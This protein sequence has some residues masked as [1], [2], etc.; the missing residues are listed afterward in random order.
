MDDL[1]RTRLTSQNLEEFVSSI[2]CIR[3]QS[4]FINDGEIPERVVAIGDIHGDL[5][6][7]FSILLKSGIIDIGGKWIAANTFLVQTGDLFDKGRLKPALQSVGVAPARPGV[8][9]YN[10]IDKNGIVQTITSGKNN[11]EF[12]EVGDELII[13]KFLCDLH[14]QATH[15]DKPFGNS[16]VLLC[17]GNHEFMNTAY[18]DYFSN[19]PK[20]EVARLVREGTSSEIQ[21]EITKRRVKGPD[22]FPLILSSHSEIE[23]RQ[24]LNNFVGINNTIDHQYAHPMD[25][26]LFGGPDFL[27]RQEIFRHGSG[28]LA[29][30]LA[31]ILNAV[32]VV[33]DFL[34]SHGGIS[35]VNLQTINDVRE[36]QH[37]N[38]IFRD[39]LMGSPTDPDEIE[40]YFSS[41]S[42]I[43]WNRSLGKEYPTTQA[44]GDDAQVCDNTLQLVETKLKRPNLNI[45][46]G[47][48][49]QGTCMDPI[50]DADRS[51]PRVRFVWNRTN[52]HDGSISTCI[53]LPTVWCKDRIYRIDT[54]ISRMNNAPDFRSPP[55]G[56]LN[57]LII[58]L[59][60]DGSK[61]KVLAMNGILGLRR[62]IQR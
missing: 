20:E 60:P 40:R 5:E 18:Y 28:Y 31:C 49:V 1:R 13:L 56:R 48:D 16:R 33:G 44:D 58:D 19:T 38:D 43:L 35:P 7:L 9:P 27:I 21:A 24:I 15:P 46:V 57:S 22:G 37:I 23:N 62:P 55:E 30:K 50:A 12:G 41:Q 53:T 59:N 8:V 4:I 14:Q 26:M 36:L 34:F 17:T 52:R 29:K 25:A 61:K 54:A 10:V 47:H 32:V 2:G 11:F 39:Y 3:G 6:A 45:V 42:S 51:V